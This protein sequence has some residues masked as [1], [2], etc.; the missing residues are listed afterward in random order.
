[1]KTLRSGKHYMGRIVGTGRGARAILPIFLLAFAGG[2][3]GENAKAA[4]P[5][6]KKPRIAAI[7]TSYYHNSHA[8]VL[9]SRCFQGHLLNGQGRFPKLELASLY[10]DQVQTAPNYKDV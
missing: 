6:G 2:M 5:G 1:M 7:V 8:D 3:A 9:V 4:E 10:T